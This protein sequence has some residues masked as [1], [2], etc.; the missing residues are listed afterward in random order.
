MALSKRHKYNLRIRSDEI[1]DTCFELCGI[2]QYEFLFTKA[3][4]SLIDA[5]YDVLDSFVINEILVKHDVSNK[6]TECL[7]KFPCGGFPGHL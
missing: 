7:I 4:Q 3:C 5:F 2:L 6:V 1:I